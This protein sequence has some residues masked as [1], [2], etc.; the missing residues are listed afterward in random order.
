M[1]KLVLVIGIVFLFASCSR[2]TKEDY[3]FRYKYLVQKV[4]SEYT[5]YTERDWLRTDKAL[6]HIEEVLNSRFKAKLTTEDRV[7][8][9]F[10]RLQYNSCRYKDSIKQTVDNYI[11]GISDGIEEVRHGIDFLFQRGREILSDS[12][13]R[14]PDSVSK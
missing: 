7:T 8:I 5:G 1:K 3:L 2:L 4:K 11:D 9:G 13:E 10:Y 6:N 12:L 14:I